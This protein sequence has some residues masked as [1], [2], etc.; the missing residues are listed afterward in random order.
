MRLIQLAYKE[1]F[2]W[3]LSNGF[4]A[5]SSNH[6]KKKLMDIKL[7][8]VLAYW[9]I[10]QSLWRYQARITRLLLFQFSKSPS[11]FFVL[12]ILL[13]RRSVQCELHF[14]YTKYG[15][16]SSILRNSH[17]RMYAIAFLMIHS[18]QF[19]KIKTATRNVI[20]KSTPR[21][22]NAK[23]KRAATTSTTNKIPT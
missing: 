9:H 13:L 21:G 14:W 5:I 17:F 22:K 10:A 15:R 12:F 2:Y 23:K 20:E 16:V 6:K 18:L 19:T 8:M 1:M 11:Y 3:V 4:V 7:S